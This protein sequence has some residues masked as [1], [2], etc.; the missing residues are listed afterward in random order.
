MGDGTQHR[1]VLV[2]RCWRLIIGEVFLLPVVFS[3]LLAFVLFPTL[4]ASNL[5]DR[6][7]D[8]AAATALEYWCTDYS[9]ERNEVKVDSIQL[10]P[11]PEYIAFSDSTNTSD[12][13]WLVD[14]VPDSGYWPCENIHRFRAYLDAES[15]QLLQF[16][17][18]PDA[19]ESEYSA[20]E[21]KKNVE[22]DV[23]GLFA[24]QFVGLQSRSFQYQFSPRLRFSN[25]RLRH[26]TFRPRLAKEV[27]AYCVSMTKE[28]KHPRPVW[29]LVGMG[30]VSLNDRTTVPVTRVTLVDGNNG[31]FMC[32]MEGW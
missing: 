22:K 4:L 27:Y 12:S 5:A 23:L 8:S 31:R 3:V 13:V 10:V 24:Y 21:I 9:S 14:I 1:P 30:L 20:Q 2:R 19:G 17:G 11:R 29:V 26:S 32:V 6:R 15:Y 16:H 28:H 18:L 7:A 25:P